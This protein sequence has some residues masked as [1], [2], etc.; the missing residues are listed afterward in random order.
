MPKR[1]YWT[2]MAVAAIAGIAPIIV[3]R[4]GYSAYR[5]DARMIGWAAIIVMIGMRFLFRPPVGLQG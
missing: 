3:L 4:Y 1:A 2:I 5:H